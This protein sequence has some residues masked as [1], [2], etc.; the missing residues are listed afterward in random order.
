MRENPGRI[1][2]SRYLVLAV[3]AASAVLVGACSATGAGP[4]DAAESGA[5]VASASAAVSE[6]P[7]A[8]T[9]SSGG[10]RGDYDYGDPSTEATEAPAESTAPGAGTIAVG[11]ATGPVGT[12]LTGPD[13]LTL[14]TFAPDSP[15]TSACDGGC[16][17][18]W[19]PF[20]VEA[21]VEFAPGDGIDGDL[22]T[23]PRADG[24]LQVAYDGAPLYYFANDT[25]PGDTNGQGLG[26]NWFV[27]EP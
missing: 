18:A 5:P 17:E 6:A 1:R 11:T 12:F 20:T 22:A 14:Y 9:S 25:T 19:P 8:S 4:S 21:D 16:A 2:T 10:G 3:I 26:G 24:T 15:N 27:A 7:S 23:F 13:G